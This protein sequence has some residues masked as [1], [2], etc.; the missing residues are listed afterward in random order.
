VTEPSEQAK[1]AYPDKFGDSHS[2]DDLQN[3]AERLDELRVA[4]DAGRESMHVDRKALLTV[5]V[6][7]MPG[8]YGLAKVQD[9]W[10]ATNLFE[11]GLIVE[12]E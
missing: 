8:R 6:E 7:N 4:F 3:Y 10:L 1:A 2:F 11:S 9:E 5:I 12:K